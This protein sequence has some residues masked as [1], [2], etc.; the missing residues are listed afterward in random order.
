MAYRN[1]KSRSRWCEKE[2]RSGKGKENRI[3]NRYCKASLA[4]VFDHVM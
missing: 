2:E 4:L 1:Q 3:R